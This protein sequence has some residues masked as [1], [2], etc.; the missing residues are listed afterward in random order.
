[1]IEISSP[2]KEVFYSNLNMEEIKDSYYNHAKRA[3]KYFKI[4]NLGKYDDLYLK[5]DTLLLPDVSE[6]FRETCLEIYKLGTA[7]FFSASGSAWQAVIKKAKAKL[8]LLTDTDVLL[9]DD[10]NAIMKYV[11]GYDKNK[12]SLYLK[13]WDVNNFYGWIM[14]QKLYINGFKWV[15]NLSDLMKAL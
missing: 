14:L 1:M 12:K 10:I 13:Y 15:E 9:M 11:K 8:E 2:K 4:K 3:C 7:K 5:S 6:N